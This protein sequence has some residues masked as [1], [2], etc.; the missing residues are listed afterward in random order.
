MI[1]QLKNQKILHNK[2]QEKNTSTKLF[3][4][5]VF[6]CLGFFLNTKITYSY[7][8]QPAIEDHTLKLEQ[9]VD[10]SV[11][12]TNTTQEERNFQIYTHRY[13][14]KNMEILDDRNFV[15]L[16]VNTFFLEPKE[17]FQI[18]YQVNIPNDVVPG[19]YFSI[20]VI[21]DIDDKEVGREGGIGLNY[22]IGALIAI[23][24]INDI[25][26]SQ[27]FLEQTNTELRYK[28]PLNPFNTV[29]EYSIKNNSKYT[30]LPTGQLTIAS[31][32]NKPIFYRINE[33]E[34]RLYPQ[35]ELTFD[36]EYQGSIKDLI[37]NK[38]AIAKI[39]SEHSNQMKED[40][41]NLP[42]LTQTT[43]IGGAILGFVVVLTI[44]IILIKKNNQKTLKKAFKEKISKKY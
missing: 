43:R 18:E 23:H 4:V 9:K 36:F 8:I 32:K 42:Y 34:T 40:Q 29:I 1:W 37:T 33:Q 30:F 21:E 10:S 27:V 31:Q 39:A 22:G 35:Q 44:T 3:L 16:G 25:D 12:F 19:T 28:N 38:I 24:V 11:M 17:S 5:L 15:T 20:I 14:P 2:S 6:F 41:I 26:I 7:S 13:N